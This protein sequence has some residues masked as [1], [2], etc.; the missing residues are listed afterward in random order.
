MGS[1]GGLL[2]TVTGSP[3][4]VSLPF[5]SRLNYARISKNDPLT[6]NKSN[7]LLN[8]NLFNSKKTS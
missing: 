5:S 8:N 1:V 3:T 7:S 4:M 2:A 6:F